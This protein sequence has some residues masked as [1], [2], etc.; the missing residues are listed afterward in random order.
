MATAQR[1]F[2]ETAVFL[3]LV[4]AIIGAWFLSQN[5]AARRIQHMTEL[6][7]AELAA[8]QIEVEAQLSVMRSEIEDW[9]DELVGGE[10]EAAFRAYAA[11]IHP[12][13]VARWGRVL[14]QARDELLKLPKVTFVHLLTP[15]GRVIASSDQKYTTRGRVDERAQWALDATEFIRRDSPFEG[16]Q[17]LAAPI[18]ERGG[19]PAVVLWLGYDVDEAKEATRPERL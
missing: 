6:N 4:L 13:A 1:V 16:V 14:G 9:S 17:E 3:G 11:G 8:K 2:W 12:M 7:Q 18:R 5:L 15:D 19:R 10:A